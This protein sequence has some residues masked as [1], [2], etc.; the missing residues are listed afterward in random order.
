MSAFI[1]EAIGKELARVETA[2][3]DN[4]KHGRAKPASSD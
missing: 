3:S 1:N 2:I 4:K